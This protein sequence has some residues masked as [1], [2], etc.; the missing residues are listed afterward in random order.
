M[1]PVTGLASQASLQQFCAGF[2]ACR[3]TGLTSCPGVVGDS[4]EYGYHHHN[5]SFV[6]SFCARFSHVDVL[7]ILTPLTLTLSSVLVRLDY[8]GGRCTVH[9]EREACRSSR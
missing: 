9:I 7:E 3:V 4:S 1:D 5:S 2:A 8:A 6:I